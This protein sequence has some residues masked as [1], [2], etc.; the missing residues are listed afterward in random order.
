MRGKLPRRPGLRKTC[1]CCWPGTQDFQSVL[2]GGCRGEPWRHA[3]LQRS[4]AAQAS[5]CGRAGPQRVYRQDQ[6]QSERAILFGR[7]AAAHDHGVV[8]R[9]RS[10]SPICGYCPYVVDGWFRGR[11]RV[12]ATRGEAGMA[13]LL[14]P[15]RLRS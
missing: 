14:W 13:L 11:C 12:V 7:T 10:W 1:C 4:P 9:S 8:A 2:P 5:E 3:Q 15:G 6:V